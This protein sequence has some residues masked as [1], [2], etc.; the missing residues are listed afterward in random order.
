MG[1]LFLH[2]ESWKSRVSV[3]RFEQ[4][5]SKG[6]G[7]HG[8]GKQ[9]TH[10]LKSSGAACFP[11]QPCSGAALVPGFGSRRAARTTRCQHVVTH[12]QA[13]FKQPRIVDTATFAQKGSSR[14]ERSPRQKAHTPP[15]EFE[16]SS[17]VSRLRLCEWAPW[18]LQNRPVLGHAEPLAKL[19]CK[20]M[21]V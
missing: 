11:Q 18:C 2:A 21:S 4:V 15:S 14:T 9:G 20:A 13:A 10:H 16:I 5:P 17:E 3:A 1:P 12:L 8:S 7:A 6:S 19:C